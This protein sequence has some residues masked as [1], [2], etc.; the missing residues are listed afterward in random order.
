VPERCDRSSPSIHDRRGELNRYRQALQGALRGETKAYG[1]ALV[2]WGTGAL[3]ETAR[4]GP[5]VSG[6]LSLVGGVL[7]SMAIVMVSAFGGPPRAAERRERQHF[8][9]GGIHVVA[10]PAALAVGWALAAVIRTRWLA[11]LVA[12]FAASATYHALLGLEVLLTPP[13]P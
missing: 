11:Y 8:G 4:R 12:G 10:V 7:L 5:G 13:P 3:S 2:V 1:F 9:L 6:T